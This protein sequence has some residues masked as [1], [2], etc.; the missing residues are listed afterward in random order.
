MDPPTRQ[1][2]SKS[3][4]L[5][6]RHVPLFRLTGSSLSPINSVAPSPM[7]NTKGDF[8]ITEMRVKFYLI[9]SQAPLGGY[10]PDPL[11][12]LLSPVATEVMS[13]IMGRNHTKIPEGLIICV[14]ACLFG[15]LYVVLQNSNAF[16]DLMCRRMKMV[17]SVQ[18]L[19]N[20]P[21]SIYLPAH[22]CLLYL[23]RI[24]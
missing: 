12:Q 14:Q 9:A 21:V 20:Y 23:V 11:R 6:T 16:T 8:S 17:G 19:I 13:K 3:T 24:F 22:L 10:L 2:S 7:V 5:T 4:Y 18:E 15:Y 1:A